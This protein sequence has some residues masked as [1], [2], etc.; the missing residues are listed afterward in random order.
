[1]GLW[2][3]AVAGLNQDTFL[4]VFGEGLSNRFMSF[5][6][7]TFLLCNMMGRCYGFSQLCG[8]SALPHPGSPPSRSREKDKICLSKALA[9]GLGWGSGVPVAPAASSFKTT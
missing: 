1:M 4:L 5:L 6:G 9:A 2:R 3:Q 7:L 8:S